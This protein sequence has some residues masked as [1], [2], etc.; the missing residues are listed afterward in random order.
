MIGRQ[1]QKIRIN[2]AVYH[3]CILLSFLVACTSSTPVTPTVAAPSPDGSLTSPTL[4]SLPPS[5]ASPTAELVPTATPTPLPPDFWQKLP[6]IP[7][8]ISDRV[9][10]IYH[11]GQTLG[12]NPHVF[13]R[14]GDCAS[15]APAFLVGFDRNYNLG[16]Y[17]Y[18]QPA[19][20][21]FR[22]SFERPS[23]GCQKWIELRRS[24]DHSLDWR[25]VPAQ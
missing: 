15:A 4:T 16:E 17:T 24:V 14:I 2:T 21:Y 5:A 22:G 9:H 12:N 3:G 23:L 7:A 18:L 19:I 25:Q 20:D 13:S 8:K 10:D 11:Y 6:I 1:L